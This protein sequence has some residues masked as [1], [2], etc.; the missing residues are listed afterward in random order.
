MAERRLGANDAR[1]WG[2]GSRGEP[3][4][5]LAT[6]PPARPPVRPSDPASLAWIQTCKFSF[7]V[8]ELEQTTVREPGPPRRRQSP[9]PPPRRPP[10]PPPPEAPLQRLEELRA[11]GKARPRLAEAPRPGPG[12]RVLPWLLLLAVIG[13]AGVAGLWAWEKFGMME[14]SLASTRAELDDARGHAAALDRRVMEVS[15]AARRAEMELAEAKRGAARR[16]GEADAVASQLEEALGG[17]QGE[18]VREDGKLTVH[19]VDKVLFRLGEAE[20]TERGMEVLAAVGKALDQVPERQIWVQGHTDDVPIK[21]PNGRFASNWELSAARALT[22][23]HY[24]Q[25]QAGI[26]PAR[27]AAVAFSEYR[28]VSHKRKSRNRRI[29]IVLFPAEVELARR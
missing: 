23:V 17:G 13:G 12:R 28:P 6:A 14:D 2:D 11:R 1:R 4:P 22:V 19:L 15:V 3:S 21:D 8:F 20:L 5:R 9:F 29:E 10:P 25:E 27:L 16:E 26:D 7:E 24:L 18:L